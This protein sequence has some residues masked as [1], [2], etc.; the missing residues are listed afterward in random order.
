MKKTLLFVSL[1]L[2]SIS[3]NDDD[4]TSS[5]KE[6][7]HELVTRISKNGITV[8][9][10]FYDDE[11]RLYRHNSFSSGTLHMYTLYEYNEHGLKEL[12]RHYAVDNSVGF[13][14]VFSLDNL[15]RIIKS[16][17]YSL[18][19]LFDQTIGIFNFEYNSSGQLTAMQYK[20]SGYWLYYRDEN[21]FSSDGNLIKLE[22]LYHP[23]T[24]QE[25]IGARYEFTPATQLMPASWQDFVFTLSLSA[26]DDEIW[27]MFTSNIS[28]KSWTGNGVL[29]AEENTEMSG[30]EYDED[31][32]LIRLVTIKKNL[33]DPQEPELVTDIT[34]DYKR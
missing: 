27:N 6:T 4:V 26:L 3:C 14:T 9:E 12:R 10:L 19:D 17:S 25:Y 32:N 30:L 15:G 5:A 22:R 8:L 34:Y 29:N 33:L 21:T 16:E 18:P 31:G 2:L 11:K 1:A 23:N 7:N 13:R 24:E 28:F 20:I